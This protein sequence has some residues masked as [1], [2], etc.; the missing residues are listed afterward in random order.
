MIV[1]HVRNAVDVPEHPDWDTHVLPFMQQY[2]NLYPVMS[3]WLF[4]LADPAV[5]AAHAKILAFAFER[6]FDDPN[7]MPV[8]RDLSTGKRQI[9]LN[10][11]AQH[12]GE[13][14]VQ[15]MASPS[16]AADDID[17][18]P[19]PPLPERRLEDW[20]SIRDALP[21]EDDGKSRAAREYAQAQIDAINGGDA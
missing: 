12:T 20:I 17:E 1:A 14:A 10:W 9:V 4:S 16:A 3:K 15:I 18:T 7:H 6:P 2:D 21:L 5:A 19:G 8:T 11:L 13:P